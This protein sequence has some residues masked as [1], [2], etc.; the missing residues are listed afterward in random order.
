MPELTVPG[1]YLVV[2]IPLGDV[3]LFVHNNIYAPTG[4]SQRR[5]FFAELPRDFPQTALHIVCGDFNNLQDDILDSVTP[6]RRSETPT[7]HLL[8]WM[9]NLDVIDAWRRHHPFQRVYSSPTRTRRIDFV[10]VSQTLCDAAYK[11]SSYVEYFGLGDHLAHKVLLSSSAI[12]HGPGYWLFPRGS[13]TTQKCRMLYAKRVR[14][15]YQISGSPIT[16]ASYGKFGK[17]S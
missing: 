16:Q 14:S 3:E 9:S 8:D 17:T 13:L 1:Q 11:S 6:R 2:A 10:L 4:E 5:R 7:A 15:C 12:P